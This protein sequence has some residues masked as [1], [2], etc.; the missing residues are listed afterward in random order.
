[1]YAVGDGL[2]DLGIREV[3]SAHPGRGG[4]GFPFGATVGVVADKLHFLAVDRDH[5]LAIGQVLRGGVV[6]VAEP[7]R[8][9]PDAGPL[10]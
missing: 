2:S 7:G 10:R 9:G 1:M 5:G 6:D 3:V 8:L 4:F